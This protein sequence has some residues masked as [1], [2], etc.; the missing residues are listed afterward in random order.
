MA[1][2]SGPSNPVQPPLGIKPP[3][4]GFALI[5]VGVAVGIGFEARIFPEGRAQ[6]AVGAPII[7]A[8][9]VFGA[10]ANVTFHRVGTDDRFSRPTSQIVQHG[11]FRI[12]RNP[13]YVGMLVITFGAM[14]A[15]NSY[16]S[17]L[18]LP[19]LF[20]YLQF[21][22]IA[23]ED[24]ERYLAQWFGREYTDYQARVRRWI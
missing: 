10:I 22:V 14:L 5:A 1:L 4:V 18:V 17:L 11:V 16:W 24:E 19:A 7:L 12:S 6:F 9:F 2:G 13:M 21:G 3:L 20:A 23:R 8:G 15:V